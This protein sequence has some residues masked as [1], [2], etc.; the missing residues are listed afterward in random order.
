MNNRENI[1]HLRQVIGQRLGDQCDKC[2]WAED[3]EIL[4]IC[5]CGAPE[6]KPDRRTFSP[7]RYLLHVLATLTS[8][9]WR[10]LCP[11]C[12]AV[13]RKHQFK[14]YIAARRA[15]GGEQTNQERTTVSA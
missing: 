6:A 3:P 8:G 4:M 1:A 14:Q 2:V 7:E 10:L 11:T 5:W 9:N 12:E 13:W 15:A